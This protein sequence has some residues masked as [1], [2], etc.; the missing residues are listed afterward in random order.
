ML[1]LGSLGE[2]EVAP[3]IE[4]GACGC[5]S[6]DASPDALAASIVAASKGSIL[7]LPRATAAGITRR[8]ERAEDADRRTDARKRRLSKR[9]L[10]ILRL[11]GEG[12]ENMA[13]ADTL[14]I[15]P[16]TVKKHVSTILGKL[17]AR[18]RVQAAVRAARWGLL[19]R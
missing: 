1:V 10:E 15:S 4:A 13:I 2:E 12:K 14:F 19:D 11:L 3:W 5:V 18:N 17:G 6:H 7:V 8:S 16:S 9:E